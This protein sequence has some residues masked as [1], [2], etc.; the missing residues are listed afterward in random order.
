MP[1]NLTGEA[2]DAL[3]SIGAAE[4]LRDKFRWSHALIGVK[5]ARPGTVLEDAS[6]TI[7]AQAVTGIGAMESKVAV[8]LEGIT[9]EPR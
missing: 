1:Q 3:R 2:I 8:G 4:D 5:G 9:L 7:P 6:E